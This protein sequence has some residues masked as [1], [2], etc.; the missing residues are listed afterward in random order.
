[1]IQAIPVKAKIEYLLFF[2][3]WSLLTACGGD[4]PSANETSHGQV[5][6]TGLLIEN[7]TTYSF[8]N[9]A[10]GTAE[11]IQED[12]VVTLTINLF[13]FSPNTVHAVHIHEG[14][15]EQPGLHWNMGFDRMTHRFCN[16]RS[17]GIPWAKP[18]AGDVGN[19]SVGYDGTGSF[20]LR[21]DLWRIGS[22]DHRDLRGKLL[23]I[24]ESY[25]DFTAECDPSH[26]HNHP[27]FNEKLACGIIE[28]VAEE[29]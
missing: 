21:T 18:M 4:E 8:G 3:A 15:C 10:H 29:H 1:M 23:I 20:T 14:A 25:E 26:G 11:F 22:G 27:H 7:D 24:H 5:Q 2:P 16:E 9:L 6:L 13:N 17:I 28:Q 19:V 12:C